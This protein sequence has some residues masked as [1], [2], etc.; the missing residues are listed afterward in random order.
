M[1]LLH[2][3]ILN[4]SSS[5]WGAGGE[6]VNQS[7]S[8]A[9]VSATNAAGHSLKKG[10]G[11]MPI[12]NQDWQQRLA[13]LNVAWFYTWR[14]QIPGKFSAEIEF[15]P[16]IWGEGAAGEETIAALKT[17][18]QAGQH[19][20]LLGFNEPDAK[21][22]C[23]LLAEDA[24]RLWPRLDSTGLRLGSPA[25]VAANHTWLTN[26]VSYVEKE[27]GRVDFIAV[28]WYGGANPEKF[29]KY[30]EEIHQRYHRPIWITEFAVADWNAKKRGFNRFTP[31]QAMSF[32]KAVIPVLERLD[33]VERYAWFSRATEN[34]N[35][36]PST[37]FDSEGALTPLGRVYAEY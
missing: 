28:H 33:Y 36:D 11:M 35:L 15:V 18:K 37:L 31:E 32:M 21:E 7:G 16:M 25:T 3:M 23:N 19:Q 26:F 1:A 5:A 27:N 14:A 22:H 9:V 2:L 29:L 24:A 20:N 13:S 4:L 34:L 8:N 12:K 10:I 30:L 17:G 6:I